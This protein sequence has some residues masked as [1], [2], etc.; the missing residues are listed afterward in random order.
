[1][2]RLK[3]FFLLT[4]SIMAIGFYSC[5][6][7]TSSEMASQ[8][9]AKISIKLV[10][11]PGDFQHVYVDVL[12]VMVKVNDDSEDES[13]WTSVGANAGVYDLLELTGGVNEILVEAY[14]VPAGVL[15]QIRLV[16]GDNNSV[17]IDGETFSLNTPSAQQSGLKIKVDQELEAGFTYNFIL[18]FDADKSVVIAGNSGNINLKPV[19]NASLEVTSGK[20]QGAITPFDF[21][22][23]VSVDVDGQT[24]STYT[25]EEGA[26]LLNGIPEGIY[27]VTITPDEDSGYA[28]TTVSDVEVINGQITDVGLITLEP[29]PTT[30]T[31]TG[32]ITN[33]G[34]TVTASIMVDSEVVSVMA[35]EMGV[36]TFEDV[37][38]G[39]YIVTITPAED[40]GL[41]ETQ[42][43]D[44]TVAAGEITDLGEITL[45]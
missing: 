41:T 35:D 6:D 42:I 11:A 29:L 2:R 16:L 15:N 18:D 17:V 28:V 43:T 13:G 40:S 37:V 30:G 36:F 33:D 34:V 14:E 31:I 1:M 44:V 38:P 24:R 9:N 27:E 20:I 19:I 45:E 8:G 26:F 7:D 22:T 39:T 25:D 23:M 5:N 10:D 4:F 3:I 32:T 21:Q 12:D